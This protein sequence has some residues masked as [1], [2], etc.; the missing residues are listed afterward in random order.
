M[1]IARKLNYR[2]KKQK[3]QQLKNQNQQLQEQISQ[4]QALQ[5]ENPTPTRSHTI[6][7]LAKRQGNIQSR[8]NGLRATFSSFRKNTPTPKAERERERA[9]S[10][11]L[12]KL[13]TGEEI[14][15]H[16]FMSDSEP[17]TPT[18]LVGEELLSTDKSLLDQDNLTQNFEQAEKFIKT[19]QLELDYQKE[20]HTDYQFRSEHETTRLRHLLTSLE[21]QL[22]AKNQTIFDLSW[23]NDQ[24]E[25]IQRAL[26]I[27]FE[28]V[29]SQ[30]DNFQTTLDEI[31]YLYEFEQAR[32]QILYDT[33]K[34]VVLER[35]NLAKKYALV[36][37]KIYRREKR[38]NELSQELTNEEELV[39]LKDRRIDNLTGQINKLNSKN[40][41]KQTQIIHLVQQLGEEQVKNNSSKGQLAYYQDQDS[42]LRDTIR[43]LQSHVCPS[44]VPHVCSP[45]SLPHLPT[46]HVCPIVNNCSHSDYDNLKNELA[47][48][49]LII[50]QQAQRIRE[51][52]NKPPVVE[53]KTREVEKIKEVEKEVEKPTPILN[54]PFGEDLSQIIEIN[55]QGLEKDLNILLSSQTKEQF[56][57]ATN[58]QELSSLRNKEIK[59]YLE[60]GQEGGITNQ[61]NK[62]ITQ[63]FKQERVFWLILLIM[64]LLT[65]GG[66]IVK[67]SGVIN[68]EK[69]KS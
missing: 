36:K 55:L 43:D 33:L 13:S 20:R 60:K 19:L 10:P 46:S 64:S 21:V 68:K 24:L 44:P 11:I 54:T 26:E 50:Q 58:Y 59:S 57:K 1:P 62:E 14:S 31:S 25:A 3:I 65:V 18:T 7:D 30:R 22:K 61:P 16:P 66:L 40:N 49:E 67:L 47:E 2:Q 45:C 41:S 23:K 12:P 42:K 35:E 39:D 69:K 38:L 17:D 6:K 56:Q 32:N 52:E 15:A 51:L 48:K 63:P 28:K 8:L 37:G 34:S 29:C 5:E 53:T 4:L 27:T 9:T